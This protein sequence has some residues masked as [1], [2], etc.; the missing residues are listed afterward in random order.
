MRALLLNASVFALVCQAQSPPD[1]DAIM[2]KV[3]GT[4][5][6]G[7]AT[8][9]FE[10]KFTRV[11]SGKGAAGR[12][13]FSFKQPNLYR[14]EG[15]IPGLSGSDALKELV[16][17]A[18]GTDIWSYDKVKNEYFSLP[19]ASV[20]DDDDFDDFSP[21][22]MDTF[23]AKRFRSATYLAPVS[24]FL[25]EETLEFNGAKINCYL[26]SVNGRTWWIDSKSYR[27][28]R[29]DWEEGTNIVAYY[30]TI[31]LGEPI[32]DKVFKFVPPQGAK[33]VDPYTAQ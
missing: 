5:E 10:I 27:V 22:S 14:V 17:V 3:T 7:S 9:E 33:K 23:M 28:V 11:E 32:A 30:E 29:E 26:I 12:L 19:A 8:Y 25:R 21:E 1:I 16:I 18:D 6:A 13:H 20:Q 24:K 15:S 31:K 4:Y 2:K